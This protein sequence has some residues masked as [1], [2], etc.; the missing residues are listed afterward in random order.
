MLIVNPN[1]TVDRTIPLGELVPGD[2]IR[3]GRAAVTLG[4]KGI[5]VARVG[6]AFGDRAPVLGFLP[7]ESRAALDALCAAEGVDL[8]GVGVAGALRGAAILIESRGRGTVLK[9]PGPEVRE[10]DWEALLAMIERQAVGHETV[11]C[12]GSLPPGS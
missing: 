7:C 9:E 3:T 6:R 4:G 5:N 8:S 1:L 12:A 11:V 10:P 2:V